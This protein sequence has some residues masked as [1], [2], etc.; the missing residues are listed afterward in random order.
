M[1][2]VNPST[3]GF[4]Q[5]VGAAKIMF[6]TLQAFLCYKLPTSHCAFLTE[7]LSVSQFSFFE[8]VDPTP[9]PPLSCSSPLCFLYFETPSQR[10]KIR[11][12]FLLAFHTS[13][14]QS[15]LYNFVDLIHLDDSLSALI[16]S[17]LW[18]I[19]GQKQLSK[20]DNNAKSKIVMAN[21]PSAL[22]VTKLSQPKSFTVLS[23]PVST[24]NT[25]SRLFFAG[26]VK[27]SA[28]AYR[29]LERWI[30]R[31]PIGVFDLNET[32]RIHYSPD[33]LHTTDYV[34]CSPFKNTSVCNYITVSCCHN[35][36]R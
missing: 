9:P 17:A 30:Q 29:R 16:A 35:V 32:F 13:C 19:H 6:F 22:L 36:R 34:V 33:N 27:S 25:C 31:P 14:L 23:F 24:K 7:T 21:I 4:Y 20:A 28:L 26:Y 8:A 2:F 3:S 10:S 5:D 1:V 15:G 12:F 18:L 11:P